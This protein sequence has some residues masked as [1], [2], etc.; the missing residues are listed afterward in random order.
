MR[1]YGFKIRE[2]AMAENRAVV[3]EPVR[4]TNAIT[5][6]DTGVDAWKVVDERGKAHFYG[7]RWDAELAAAQAK[8]QRQRHESN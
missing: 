2:E 8:E 1:G 7:R 6:D 4:F 5:G 3:A